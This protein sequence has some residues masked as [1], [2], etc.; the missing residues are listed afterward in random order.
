MRRSRVLFQLSA[1]LLLTTVPSISSTAEAAVSFSSTVVNQN[2]GNCMDV[3]WGTSD[4]IQLIQWS[5]NQGTNQSF[6]FAPV[7]GTTDH[8]TINTVAGK[9]AGV[10]GASTA[11]NAT[12]GQSACSGDNSQKFQLVPVSASDKTFNLKAVHSGKCIVPSGDSSAS[13]TGLVQ[14]PCSSATSR[15]WQLPD[16][17][18]SGGGG[19]GGTGTYEGFPSLP[20]YNVCGNSGLGK[21]YGTNFPTPN[22][23]YSQGYYNTSALGWDGNYWPVTTFLSG[24]YFARG[25]NST[26]NSQYCGGMYSFSAYNYGGNHPAQSVQWTMDNG[27]LPALKTQFTSGSVTIAIKNF[28]NKVTLNGSAFMLIYT[29]VSVTN[30]GSSSVTVSPGGSG[31][32]LVRLTSSSLDTVAAGATNNHDFVAAVDNFGSGA[33]FPSTSTLSSSAPNYDTAYSQMSS[34]WNGRLGE[35]NTFSLPNVS[36]PNTGNLANPGTAMTNAYKAATAYNLIMQ[37]GKAQFSAANNYAYILNHDVPGEL[38]AKLSTGDFHDAQNLLLTARIS[39]TSGWDEKG[40]NW[41]W[42]GVWKTPEIWAIYLAKTGDTSFVNSY[43]H[44]DSGGSSKWGPS[45]Y[46][47]MHN[48]YQGQLDSDGTLQTNFDNDSTGKWLFSNYSA[49]IGLASYK[50]IATRLGLTSE[51]TYADT[52]YTNLLNAL[53]RVVGNN[54]S[55]NGFN[56]L[57]CEVDK[58]NSAN[59]CNTFND[60]NWASPAWAG[61]NQFDTMLMG[62]PLNGVIG[63][64]GQIDRMYQWGF[65]RLSAQG[66]PYPTFGAFN[67]YSTG[68]NTF[69]ASDGLY[70]DKYRDMPITSYAWQL[71]TTTGGPNAWWEA[72]G[73]GPSSSNPWAGNH[74]G[75][76]FGACPYAWPLAGQQL[77]LLNS[78]VAEGLASSGSGPYTYSRPLYIGRGIPNSWLAA[79]QTVSVSNLTSSYNVSSGSRSTYG[80]SIAVTNPGARVITVNITGTPPGGTAYIS[81]PVFYGS[82]VTSV[83]GGSYNSSTHTVTATG[84]TITIN[85]NN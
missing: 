48:Y 26:Y 17:T 9:C 55:A 3:P 74:A 40:A 64:P 25:V 68:Y 31:P 35:L 34:Y 56:Y 18:T 7:S 50:Y 24:S 58:P 4:D 81:L 59:R 13:N 67:G 61:Q 22:D 43:F 39:E 46:T 21:S 20:A 29:R 23:P 42:D 44:D 66:Y 14:L 77:G 33:A 8:Y 75:P 71:A 30:K 19:G 27:Y 70:G 28:A 80:V 60:A 45:L 57:P 51:A 73:D 32:N 85:L 49:L 2:G 78:I 76:E 5:C 82:S 6:T 41:Y 72:N 53:N 38:I 63:D 10:S 52:A 36:L 15:V 1:A 79:G 11:D 69:Y 12:V 54:E 37:V 47:M 62:G 65:A 16:Y 83:S 84:N